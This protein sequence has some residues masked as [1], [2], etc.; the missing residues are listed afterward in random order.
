MRKDDHGLEFDFWTAK[1]LQQNVVFV[2]SFGVPVLKPVKYNTAFLG[3]SIKKSIAIFA[4]PRKMKD[5]V[6]ENGSCTG[7]GLK[8]GKIS[9]T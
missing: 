5:S 9:K 8:D 3:V 4:K 6:C 1:N 7:F 2:A